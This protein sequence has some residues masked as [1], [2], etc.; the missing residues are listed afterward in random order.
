[1]RT[2]S[3]VFCVLC[4]ALSFAASGCR[5]TVV[6]EVCGDGFLDALEE[7]DDGNNVDGDGCSRSCLDE[8]CGNFRIEPIEE[9]DDGNNVDGDGCSFD[10]FIEGVAPFCGDGSVNTASEECDDG[11]NNDFDGCS[12]TCLL[13]STAYLTCIDD[14]DCA[15]PDTCWDVIIPAEATDGSVCTATCTDD[16]DCEDANTFTGACYSL[17][18]TAAVCYQRCD[19]TSDCY[20]DNVCISVTLPGGVLDGVCVPDNTP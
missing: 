15:S 7:C 18:S 1:M 20:I 17:E 14:L 3:F 9:C 10:C 16:L 12:A 2:S 6:D 5:I 8:I 13:E 4:A 19:M 11:N